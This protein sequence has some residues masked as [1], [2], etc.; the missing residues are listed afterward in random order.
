M[1]KTR[2]YE[3]NWINRTPSSPHNTA[4]AEKRVEAAENLNPQLFVVENNPDERESGSDRDSASINRDDH[5]EYPEGGLRAW[6]VVLG[7]W[8]ALFSSLGIMNTL[9]TFLTYVKTHQLSEY[10][11][12]TLGWVFSLYTFVCFF[13]G[14][15]FG[16]IFDKYGPRWLIFIG[17]ISIAVSLMLLSISTRESPLVKRVPPASNSYI[18]TLAFHT[19]FWIIL[20]HGFIPPIHTI[21]RFSW[22]LVPQ[23]TRLGNGN[24]IDWRIIRRYCVSPYATASFCERWMGLGRQGPRIHMSRPLYSGQLPHPLASSAR[25]KRKDSSRLPSVQEPSL[26]VD[27][28]SC[29]P[30]RACTLHPADI[31]LIVRSTK[32]LQLSLRIPDAARAQRGI[33]LWPCASGLLGR[34][35]RAVQ[36]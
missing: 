36:L 9:G 10:D 4:E 19:V 16:P 32:G 5:E 23:E 13:L 31:H 27:D 24:G 26:L 7:S 22:P 12:G 30:S 35:D 34:Q 33:R 29:V 14:V 15:Y 18:R 11:E 20:W 17:T 6:L 28:N 21:Y 2:S 1:E 25:R 8:L 3:N